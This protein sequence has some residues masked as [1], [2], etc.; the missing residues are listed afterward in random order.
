MLSDEVVHDIKVLGATILAAAAVFATGYATGKTHAASSTV[1]DTTKFASDAKTVKK[2]TAVAVTKSPDGTVKTVT[3][4]TETT[5][6]TK[7]TSAESKTVPAK[8]TFIQALAGVDL[9]RSFT[10]TYGI[11]VSREVLGP[12]TLGAYGL[13]SGVV[14]VTVG[15]SF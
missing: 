9:S 15:V 6:D 7:T 14:G 2:S 4:T 11:A 10:P 5:G 1:E 12:I 8:K 3:T 13:T